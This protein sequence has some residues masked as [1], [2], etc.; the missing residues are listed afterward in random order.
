MHTPKGLLICGTSHCGKSTLAA[1]LGR[2]TGA[3]VLA[4]DQMARHPGRPWPQPRP[5]VVDFYQNLSDVSRLTLLQHH[6]QTMQGLILQAIQSQ[7]GPYIIEGSA[8]RPDAATV[9][10]GHSC[11]V[12]CLTAPPDVL[13]DRIYRESG[14]AGLNP[15]QRSLVQAFVRRSLADQD[16]ILATASQ[17]DVMVIDTTD[18]SARENFIMQASAQLMA[19]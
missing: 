1:A 17:L 6:Y 12:I 15:D 4:T 9:Y 11:E 14:Y 5:H 16:I 7:S 13:A 18:P 19:G 2:Q 10:R 3:T 8:L